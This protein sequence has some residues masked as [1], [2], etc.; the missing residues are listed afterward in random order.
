MESA[1]MKKLKMVVLLSL[2]AA[3]LTACVTTSYRVEDKTYN[4]R[5]EALAA[6][7]RRDADGEAGVSAGAGPL[8]DRKLLVVIPTAG[9]IVKTYEARLAKQGTQS[10]SSGTPARAQIDFMADTQASNWKSV[11]TSLRKAN[12]YREVEVIDVDSTTSNYQPSASQDVF[13][14]YISAEG[15]MATIYF[16]NAKSGKQVVAIDAGKPTIGERRRSLIDDVKAK[17]LQ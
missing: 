14:F 12:I 5:D 1:T 9:A 2:A 3:I 8:V 17:A 11:A 10:P 6:S 16:A 7:M 15:G 4:S 13:S